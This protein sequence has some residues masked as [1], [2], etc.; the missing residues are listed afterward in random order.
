[1]TKKHKQK[2]LS[3]AELRSNISTNVRSIILFNMENVINIFKI[4]Y[5]TYK[6]Y[7]QTKWHSMIKK[8]EKERKKDN[9]EGKNKQRN[10]LWYN[11][12]KLIW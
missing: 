5:A 2:T 11:D 12:I 4:H 8:W 10:S 1:M 9:M 6:R 3:M 7:V